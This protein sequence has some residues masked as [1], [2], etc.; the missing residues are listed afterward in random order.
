M[1]TDKYN[2]A[3]LWAI[4]PIIMKLYNS[5]H[6]SDYENGFRADYEIDEFQNILVELGSDEEP[7]LKTALSVIQNGA[8]IKSQRH[9]GISCILT[10]S[11]EREIYKIPTASFCIGTTEK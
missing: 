8:G 11:I 1:F 4:Q 6:Q 9:G 7:L 2:A 5:R 3:N 10:T